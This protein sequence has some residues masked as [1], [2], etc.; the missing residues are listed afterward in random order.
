MTTLITRDN[1][2]L[3]YLARAALDA[4]RTHDEAVST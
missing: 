2:L 1:D 4:V 3:G